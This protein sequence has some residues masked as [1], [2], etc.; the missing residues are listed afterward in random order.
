LLAVKDITEDEDNSWQNIDAEFEA[1]G[2]NPSVVKRNRGFIRDWIT[3]V[4]PE[5]GEK[6][7]TFETGLTIVEN[8]TA[9]AK[10]ITGTES[11]IAGLSIEEINKANETSPTPA[12]TEPSAV[13]TAST[14]VPPA[15]SPPSEPPI[16]SVSVSSRRSQASTW[17]DLNTTDTD[18]VAQILAKVLKSKYGEDCDERYTLPIKRSFHHLDWTNRGWISFGEVQR[19]CREAGTLAGFS[20]NELALGGLAKTMDTDN[21]NQVNRDEFIQIV[22]AV[23]LIILEQFNITHSIIGGTTEAAVVLKAFFDNSINES[24]LPPFWHHASCWDYPSNRSVGGYQHDLLSTKQLIA[25]LQANFTNAAFIAT[26]HCN[27]Q[28]TGALNKWRVVLV[29]LP[30]EEAAEYIE[31]LDNALKATAK[32]HNFDGQ[33]F[34]N[35]VYPLDLLR[36]H[37]GMLALEQFEDL[38]GCPTS[39]VL[40]LSKQCWDLL[41]PIVGFVYDLKPQSLKKVFLKKSAKVLFELG[42]T[43]P[44]LA[45]W[46]RLRILERSRRIAS[47]LPKWEDMNKTS[48]KCRE[49]LQAHD[50]QL[51]HQVKLAIEC[52]KGLHRL[53]QDA[54]ERS[55]VHAIRLRDISLV[56]LK[57]QGFREYTLPGD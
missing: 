4:I 1:A 33:S 54:V 52:A 14:I 55:S 15:T 38:S 45:E 11:V 6:E 48:Q 9:N 28:I 43:P 41:D 50:A 5:D 47:D 39:E 22:T 35:R 26:T 30:K 32:F 25:P 40:E 49:W 13:T 23:R 34:P 57:R 31:A 21:N 18:F 20:I 10:G 29:G 19:Y 46:R 56:K 44:A 12:P 16:R 2:F 3:T 37:T 36:V 8:A 24:M 7:I 42:S 51:D 53:Q 27:S 17:Q